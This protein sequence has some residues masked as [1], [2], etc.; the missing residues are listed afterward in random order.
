V[1]RVAVRQALKRTGG[2]GRVGAVHVERVLALA[3]SRMASG[4]RLPLPGGREV[5][6]RLGELWIGPR[7]AVAERAELGRES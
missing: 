7:P 5:R 3:R 6:Y 4:R 1:A 2:L